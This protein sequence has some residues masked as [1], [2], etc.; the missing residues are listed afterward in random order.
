MLNYLGLITVFLAGYLVNSGL[1]CLAAA[2]SPQSRKELLSN[3]RVW[4]MPWLVFD[5]LHQELDTVV[6]ENNLLTESYRNLTENLAASVI[7]RDLNGKVIYCSPY[8][9]VLTGYS[10]EEIY[11]SKQDFFLG[12]MHKDDQE[13]YGRA[14]KVASLGEAFQF[15]YRYMHRS[16]IEMWAETR[17]VPMLNEVGAITSSLSITLDV[18]ATVRYQRQMEEQAQNLAEF[19]YMISHDLKAPIY[20]IKGMIGVLDEDLKNKSSETTEIIGHMRSANLRLESLVGSILQY[21]KISSEELKTE[22]VELDTVLNDVL[23]DYAPQLASG[24]V[25]IVRDPLPSILGDRIK[26]YQILSNIVGNAIK[27]RD[28]SRE[29][30]IRLTAK[31]GVVPHSAVL[32]VED[33]GLG[34]PKDK[35]ET[36][37]RPFQRAHGA[38]IEGSG[39]GL[40]CVKKLMERLGGEVQVASEENK[41]SEF[42]LVFRGA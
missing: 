24:K 38:E 12:I 4:L 29:A 21:C 31:N 20:T 11:G 36:I 26:V 40:A 3:W 13:R 22:V 28:P 23:E 1:V 17:S 2:D 35:L 25:K 14:L 15:R 7:V 9:E 32:S 18:T 37:F 5:R 8:T 16:G 19:S 39:I 30:A 42:R 10:L 27:F 41:G 6:D 33:N 34:I